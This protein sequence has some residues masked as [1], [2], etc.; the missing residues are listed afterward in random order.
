MESNPRAALS[1]FIDIMLDA[2][3]A[4]DAEANIVYVSASCERIF[5]YTPQEMIGKNMFDMM[6]P[7]DREMTRNSVVEV[8]SG[9]PQFHFENRYV[10]K[11][12]Q[13]V[14][15]MWSARWSPTEQLR[16]GVA[17]D[18]TERKR[19]ELLKSA[20]YSITEAVHSTEDLLELFQRIHEII[21]TLLPADNFSVMLYDDETSQ[22]SFPY[23]VDEFITAPD[24]FTLLPGTLYSEVIETGQPLLYTPDMTGAPQ[25]VRQL[26]HGR[27]PSCW[28]G[29]PLKSHRGTI[30]VLMIKSYLDGVGYKEKDQE[31][32]QF[33]S[34][35][36]VTAIERQQMQARLQHM[37]QYD[38]LT[39]LPNR[40][41]LYDRIDIALFTA[42]RDQGQLAL[43][44]IDLDKFKQVNDT[45][46]HGIGDLLLQETAARLASCVGESDTVSRIGGDEFVILLQKLTQPEQATVVAERV[47]AAF[48]LP[49]TLKGNRLTIA[50][51]LGIGIYPQHGTDKRQLL[52]HADNDMYLNKKKQRT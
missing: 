39:D 21:R 43:L 19:S 44:Y 12:G 18:I 25:E 31:L 6:L 17:R 51:S 10:H 14:N 15:I 8:M 11:H 24:P 29:V 36:I 37:A 7:E 4:V 33:V 35:Q 13:I 1:N 45:L 30:G 22:L 5:G 28:L 16:V 23:H 32:L 42:Q 20:L 47:R 46:G 27:I 52:E 38:Q 40:G 2:V 34:T 41:L 3:F 50:P 49:F 48:H 26:S 9:H